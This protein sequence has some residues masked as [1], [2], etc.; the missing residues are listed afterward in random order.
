MAERVNLGLGR[1]MPS[2]RKML[3]SPRKAA[4]LR[5][6]TTVKAVNLM[7]SLRNM[8]RSPRKTARLRRMMR[9]RPRPVRSMRP[10]PR[11][12][13]TPMKEW[14]MRRAL[15]TVRM[16]AAVEMR[17]MMAAVAMRR[18]AGSVRWTGLAEAA[19]RSPPIVSLRTS[20][21]RLHQQRL[22]STLAKRSL[23]GSLR[24]I[25]TK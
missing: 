20:I 24:T 2:L 23:K 15:M 11:K 16:V 14:R 3:R 13:L 6:M 10:R 1:G 9:M 22:I 8:L 7:P 17:R 21:R 5:R 18:L 25:M 19:V 4:R 12:A